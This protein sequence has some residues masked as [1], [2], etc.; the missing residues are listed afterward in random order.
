MLAPSAG[1]GTLPVCVRH[2]FGISSTD[3]GA[4][5]V[6]ETLVSGKIGKLDPPKLQP[7]TQ[8]LPCPLGDFD[9]SSNQRKLSEIKLLTI[10]RVRSVS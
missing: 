3:W 2:I 1:L 4:Q 5:P 10:V 7:V 9:A 8:A 6:L